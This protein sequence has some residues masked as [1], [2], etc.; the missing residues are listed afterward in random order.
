MGS[1]AEWVSA[2]A[3]LGA[4]GAAVYAGIAAWRLYRIESAR[5]GA[6][7]AERRQLQARQVSAWVA[8]AVEEE[9]VRSSGIE[10]INGSSAPV[11][12]LAIQV[13]GETGAAQHPLTLTVLPPGRFFAAKDP[14]YH[15]TFPDP[16]EAIGL[17]LRPVAKSTKWRVEH[18]KFRDSA[19]VHWTRDADGVLLEYSS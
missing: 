14:T 1:V 12:D 11:Y 10:I 2:V 18:L 17:S 4:L 7:D 6:A 8:V 3:A 16:A 19:N 15:W 13:N 9:S 5:D